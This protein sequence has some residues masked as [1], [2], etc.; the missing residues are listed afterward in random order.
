MAAAFVMLDE[1]PSWAMA[2][3]GAAILSGV[4]L[5]ERNAP[6]VVEMQVTGSK[7]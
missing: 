1:S 7:E 6:E 4:Y 3:G 5:A 2:L